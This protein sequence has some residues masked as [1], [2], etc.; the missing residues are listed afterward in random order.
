MLS[1]P[2]A[3]FSVALVASVVVCAGS[4]VFLMKTGGVRTPVWALTL[5]LD[6]RVASLLAVGGGAATSIVVDT[7]SPAPIT[8]VYLEN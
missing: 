2:N 1:L 5:A 6:V 4:R 8:S 3:V 7:M